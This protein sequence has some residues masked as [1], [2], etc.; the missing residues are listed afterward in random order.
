MA[1][2][3]DN[4]GRV[5]QVTDNLVSTL[6]RLLAQTTG[7]AKPM[8]AGAKDPNTEVA[9]KI[10][11]LVS[12][13]DDSIQEVIKQ[14]ERLVKDTQKFEKEDKKEYKKTDE[15]LGA[16]VEGLKSL[17]KGI[18]RLPAD[19][20]HE[21]S[22]A[23]GKGPSRSGV[24]GGG[25]GGGGGGGRGG[26]AMPFEPDGPFIKR[27]ADNASIKFW[28][29]FNKDSKKKW[30]AWATGAAQMLVG[31]VDPL[32]VFFQG[33]V[34]DAT[35][36]RVE[37]REIA[38]EVE[39][40]TGNMRGLQ[41]EF[42][43]IGKS[44]S[45]TG[46]AVDHLQRSYINALK[47][48]VK[49]QKQTL[50]VTKTGLHFATMIGLLPEQSGMTADMFNEWHMTLNMSE[51]SLAQIARDSQMVARQT[52]IT[53]DNL[54]KIMRASEKFMKNMKNAN[55]F[56]GASAK[57][58]MTALA[59][60]EKRGVSDQMQRILDAG[61]SSVNFF[62]ADKGTQNFF[63]AMVRDTE[64]FNK[65]L[66]GTLLKSK[67]GF[68]TVKDG[69]EQ[70]LADMGMS[71]QDLDN[72]SGQELQRMNQLFQSHFGMQVGEFKE[73]FKSME[74]GSL[75]LSEQINKL[76]NDLKNANLT[77]EEVTKLEKQRQDMLLTTGMD[78]LSKF[79][80][81]SG[82]AGK[83]LQQAAQDVVKGFD[84]ADLDA[85]AKDMGMTIRNDMDAINVAAM[86]S[87]KQL[88]DAGGKDF[89]NRIQKALASGSN[90][91]IREILGEMNAEQQKLGV[92]QK[93]GVDPITEL[94]QNSNEAN[95]YLRGILSAMIAGPLIDA[96]RSTGLM[97]MQMAT[98][99]PTIYEALGGRD[100]IAGYLVEGLTSFFGGGKG[101]GVASAAAEGATST[102]AEGAA[103]AMGG[104]GGGLQKSMDSFKVPKMDT[105]KMMEA[106]KELGKAAIGLTAVIVGIIAL[107]VA[108][109]A[110]GGALLSVTGLDAS[111]A[112]E[113]ALAITAV[114]A[115]ATLVA[116]AALAAAYGL[117]LLSKLPAEQIAGEAWKGAYAL[118]LIGLPVAAVA[119]AIL[120]LGKL[121]T[122]VVTPEE[123]V[124][125][126]YA[127]A[128]VFAATGLIALAL[129]GAGAVLALLAPLVADGGATMSALL[130]S[131]ALALGLI[132]LPVMAV[133]AA[134]LLM[135]KLLSYVVEPGYAATLAVALA[136]LFAA[137][138]M[139]ATAIVGSAV[140]LS[141]LALMAPI[142]PIVAGL[143][144]IGAL[145]L[146]QLA[147]PSVALAAAV[148]Y[149]SSMFN[150]IVDPKWAAET[151][152]AF[153]SVMVAAAK[154][155]GAVVAM[156]VF[157]SVLG[158]M[159]VLAPIIAPLMMLGAYALMAL[160]PA[161][162]MIAAAIIKMAQGSVAAFDPG[163]A[164][165]TVE[166]FAA[167]L[168]AA[169]TIAWEITKLSGTLML[170]GGMSLLAPL[171]WL[172]AYGLLALA[173]PVIMMATALMTMA[174][175]LTGRFSNAKE[176]GESLK[177]VMETVGLMSQLITDYEP[178]LSA[179]TSGSW[180]GF[181]PSKFQSA[182]MALTNGIINPLDESLPEEGVLG[183]IVTRLQML[184]DIMSNMIAVMEKAGELN[185]KMDEHNIDPKKMS[186]MVSAM[187]LGAFADGKAGEASY[188]AGQGEVTKWMGVGSNA[189]SATKAAQDGKGKVGGVAKSS[190]KKLGKSIG[191]SILGFISRIFLGEEVKR[192]DRE[193]KIAT[194]A[195]EKKHKEILTTVYDEGIVSIS[196]KAE[197]T[198]ID[199]SAEVATSV[200]EAKKVTDESVT[201]IW[202]WLFGTVKK[203]EEAALD[204][205]AKVTGEARPAKA[206]AAAAA[207]GGGGGGGALSADKSLAEMVANDPRI[208]A[209][210]EQAVSDATEKAMKSQLYNNAARVGGGD[211][212][213]ARA[214]RSINDT[215]Q[216]G[217]A[218]MMARMKQS[219]SRMQ[220]ISEMLGRQNKL[221][222]KKQ[223]DTEMR[224]LTSE[225]QK[226][227][228]MTDFAVREKAATKLVTQSNELVKRF[229]NAEGGVGY[230]DKPT[231]FI[232]GEKGLER[233]SIQKVNPTSAFNGASAQA[234]TSQASMQ[235]YHPADIA[236]SIL[237]ERTSAEAGTPNFKS[238]ELVAIEEASYQQVETLE[239]IAEGIHELVALMKPRGNSIV[240]STDQQTAS[241]RG[242]RRPMHSAQYGTLKYG[243]PGGNA[244]RQVINDG[245]S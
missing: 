76:D 189:A 212:A 224:K 229:G 137:T 177:S 181:G 203:S 171:V 98:L 196:K 161:M 36:F 232:A 158:A 13:L 241:T 202:D 219:Q 204:A 123:A 83:T 48:G 92:E 192:A 8:G 67:D 140:A 239:E 60:A 125:I 62:G 65:V 127:L 106:G 184:T 50:E 243:K 175:A 29:R 129:I 46:V 244:N 109:L 237:R 227:E 56:V 223:F 186:A 112:M 151:A 75:G 28:E 69:M 3:T 59:E 82:K 116:A 198:A 209:S 22:K 193:S 178:A 99:A 187:N 49:S 87:A 222:E 216:T 5:Q 220:M 7:P 15:R 37:M 165:D 107:A 44:V 42:G 105:G 205:K 14:Q 121:M 153:A 9:D 17:E 72:L 70:Y 217:G 68:K 149:M 179:L 120:L 130:W 71:I 228:K 96:L 176:V 194:V 89:T 207:G 132:A 138:A 57:H 24:S 16:V 12:R 148:V 6:S 146:M 242:K 157:T 226:T 113:I 52:G 199:S 210:T 156:A 64:Q 180:F 152:G 218:N 134:I 182:I 188:L 4:L 41:A 10:V 34:S 21:I 38:Y 33:A 47:K 170:L 85:L 26:G 214:A 55:T 164:K 110:V 126:S 80:D 173:P 45:R 79:S 63:K 101:G 100:G 35:K 143:M 185:A 115:G 154:I 166:N 18:D 206:A 200:E 225:I 114:I 51:E 136:N 236:E 23:L 73:M 119:A 230:A 54:V 235:P 172:G 131:G 103:N 108:I 234:S 31:G 215:T 128:N 94:A 233:I 167:I 135:G 147:A 77:A 183:S 19:F 81:E 162:T 124:K 2:L 245:E 30:A 90:K 104:G 144:L 58:L 145:G 142:A 95:E 93:K 20:A 201:S 213:A 40:I 168:Q 102:L 11:E 39:G 190:T 141:V 97:V 169:G 174:S 163:N 27:A 25:G 197:Q 160:T 159:A 150:K 43:D 66:D 221:E 139:I 211:M 118:G 32:Q 74:A 195:S 53:G 122:L 1:E 84:K 86:A 238:P 191:G 117:K 78:V 88:K 240:G 231:A 133:A 111:K 61:T 91:E 208:Q 155:A